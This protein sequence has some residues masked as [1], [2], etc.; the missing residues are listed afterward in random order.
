MPQHGSAKQLNRST[1]VTRGVTRLAAGLTV[2][3]AILAAPLPGRAATGPVAAQHG[4]VVSAHHLASQVGVDILRRGGNAVD[5]AVAVG[6]ALAVVYPAAGNLG[7]GGFMTI[8][9]ADGRATFLDFRERAPARAHETMYLDT[10]G[11]E[12]PGLSTRGWLSVAVPGSVAGLDAALAAFGTLPRDQVL[13]PAIRLAAEGF[14]L[15]VEDTAMLNRNDDTLSKDPA[16]AAIFLKNGT[17]RYRPGDRLVQPDLAA[18]LTEIATNGPDAFYRGS[19]TKAI[20]AASRQ[21]QGILE[22]EDFADYRVRTLAPVGCDYHGFHIISAPP[23]SS[24]GVVLCEILTVLE[25]YPLGYLGFHAAEGTHLMA[26]AMRHA[27]V[28]RNLVSADPDDAAGTVK[29]LLDRNYAA[30]VRATFEP[31]RAALSRELLAG[32]VP[33]EPSDGPGLGDGV[34]DPVP[35]EGSE[36]THY[37]IIDDAGTAVAVTTTLNGAFGAQVVAA[38]TGI[39]MN[40]EMD[41]FTAKPGAPN[42]YGLVQGQIN[43][44]APGK[45][46]LSSMSP[47]I[48]TKDGK[49]VMVIGSPGGPR[50]ITATL[51]V[52]Q[53]VLDFGMTIQDAID[54]PRIHHQWQPDT[55]FVEPHAL[56]SE[57]HRILTQMGYHIAEQPRW[58]MAE[59][60]LVGGPALNTPVRGPE[61]LFGAADDRG[62]DGA[63]IGY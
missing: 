53:N 17:S 50:I 15:S 21:G 38:G 46:P 31:D 18:S 61:R 36:T 62:P 58:G 43:R 45:T 22:A 33:G 27:F 6:Y 51:E 19:L 14:T 57:A 30:R 56:S 2:V 5:A 20:L 1:V 48:V 8:H 59:G 32:Q 41:D 37:S 3:M 7:G 60:I 52:I 63:A 11:N 10:Q 49:T 39:L 42:L 55:L 9:F 44:I 26:E 34:A 47:T 23:P 35:H 16:A 54:A 4:M 28:D 40:D 25:P 24:G 12:I 29:R 13:A